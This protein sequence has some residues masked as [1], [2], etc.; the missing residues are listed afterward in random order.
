MID[1]ACTHEPQQ[2]PKC[3]TGIQGLDEVTNGGL[4]RGRTSLVCG[5]AGC[6]K[7]LLAM[8]FLVNGATLYNE[9]GVFMSFEEN[10]AEL[11]ENV[12]SLGIDLKEL[13]AEKKI[14]LD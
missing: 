7:T 12:A 9:P 11:A 8:Q 3:L 2:L 13:V 14:F 10:E 5:S 4:P 6:G 1:T